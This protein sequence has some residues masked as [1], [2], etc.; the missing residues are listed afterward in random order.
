MKN[1]I[2]FLLM[3]ISFSAFAQTGTVRGYLYDEGNG[4]PVLFGNVLVDDNGTGTTTDL[5]GAYTIDLAPGT[6]S[7]TF[8]FIGYTPTT[9]SDV[10]V[11]Y[12]HLTLPTIL[13]V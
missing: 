2:S 9:V 7:I 6:Y 5:D 11:S 1:C 8:S 3:I 13:L 10:A 4:E 12:T